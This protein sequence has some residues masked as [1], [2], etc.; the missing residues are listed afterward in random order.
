MQE[1]TEDDAGYL[2]WLREH[3]DGFVVNVERN[4]RPA[5]V[6]LHRASCRTISADRDDG[7]YTERG[8]RKVVTDNLDELRAF[9]R[10]IGR[11]DGSFSKACG[12][13]NPL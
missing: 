10:S 2:G 3:P 9:A 6:I 12:R 13:C 5:Y 1:F 4:A 8:Y 11:T 7:A